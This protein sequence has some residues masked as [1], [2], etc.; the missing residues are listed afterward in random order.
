MKPISYNPES[1]GLL[2]YLED[3]IGTDIYVSQIEQLSSELNLLEQNKIQKADQFFYLEKDMQEIK[4]DKDR[5]LDFI[6]QEER[7]YK[8]RL[9]EQYLTIYKHWKDI[10]NV[11]KRIEEFQV[12][13]R[14][15]AD[16]LE[17]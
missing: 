11:V 17:E 14:L 3:I 1:P 6:R 2:E 13:K 9:L 4:Q 8:L 12:Q 10:E 5:A 7:L 16:Q 15:Y